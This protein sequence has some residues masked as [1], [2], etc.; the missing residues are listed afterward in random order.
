MAYE[1][2]I[3]EAAL[4]YREHILP[5]R[6]PE[7]AETDPEFVERFENFAFDEVVN[8]P[9]A[10]LPDR[11]RF[12]AILAALLGCQGVDE[13]TLMAE[14]ALNAGVTP[15]EL[16]EVVYQA[17]AY[18]G[19]GRVLPFLRATNEVLLARGVEL[20]LEPQATTTAETRVAAGNE[21][22]VRY[23]GEGMRE[24][25]KSGPAERAHVN[26]WLAGHCFGDWYTRGGLGDKDREL[27]TFCF[28]V[29]QGGCEPQATAHAT[30][31]MSLGNDR[32]FLYRVVSQL[33]P[34]IGY[35]RSLNALTCVDKAAEQLAESAR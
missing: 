32:D 7:L 24:S 23:F 22:Q 13:F 10:Q 31:N 3:S 11:E 4:A 25:W 9:A 6:T 30:G 33:V 18:L 21:V 12:L 8:E 19:I 28:I 27:I 1:P 15:V 17:S 35:P 20:P 29:A 2:K 16:R 5:G 14:A 26:R 34:Y